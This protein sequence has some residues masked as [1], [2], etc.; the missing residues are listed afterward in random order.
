MKR[1]YI[2]IVAMFLGAAAVSA[3]PR[4]VDVSSKATA[5]RSNSAPASF[6]AKYE[7]GMFGYNEKEVGTLKFDDEN[8]RLVFFG[9]DQKEKF[10][11]PYKS[12][13]LIYP[14]S[15]SVTST[16]GQVVQNIPLPG[17]MLGG[18]IKEKRRYLVLHFN[19]PDVEAARGLVN[20]KLDNKALLDSVIQSLA[21]KANLTQR[22]DAY[23]RPRKSKNEI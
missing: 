9:K 16:T 21:G 17:A 20:F 6:E 5:A 10:Q 2:L 14:Q 13:L 22:G 4:P 23:Y 18:L 12:V 8:Q 11:I 3:Q 15:K 1:T 19:D 7:G